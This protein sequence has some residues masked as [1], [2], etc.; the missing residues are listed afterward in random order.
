MD[1]NHRPRSYQDRVIDTPWLA[2]SMNLMRGGSMYRGVPC[3]FQCRHRTLPIVQRSSVP[4]E[5]AASESWSVTCPTDK[6]V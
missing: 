1:S 2:Q 4:Y 5:A 3:E 6:G